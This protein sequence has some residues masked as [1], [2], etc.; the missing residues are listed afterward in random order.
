MLTR[1]L[2]VEASTE[3]GA[4]N[5]LFEALAS[6]IVSTV[7][8]GGYVGVGGLT[9]LENLFPPIPSELILPVAGYLVSQGELGFV[10]VIIA[11]TLG[12][13]AG[14]LI[15]YGLGYKLGERRLRGF[16][17][18]H[19]KW[20]ALDEEDIDQAQQWFQRHG[21]LA[22][23]IGRLA[24]AVRSVISIPA[25]LSRMPLGPF[26]LYT[27]LGSAVWNALLVTAGWMLGNQWHLVEPY[28]Q[29]LEWASLIAVV[30]GIVWF[31]ARKRKSRSAASAS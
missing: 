1:A 21:G 2:R 7:Q 17:R 28:L 10:G 18:E 8:T 14:A 25:G 12:S 9:L 31:V 29:V 5:Q 24:P 30:G 15:L 26:V 3:S 23:L 19:G 20:L 16:A 11:S 27:T 13:L 22:V 4:M 6:W